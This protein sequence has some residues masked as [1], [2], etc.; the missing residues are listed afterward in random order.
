MQRV[1]PEVVDRLIE[2]S[3]LDQQFC[4]Q[5]K[6]IK[7]GSLIFI[8]SDTKTIAMPLVIF[9]ICKNFSTIESLDFQ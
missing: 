7:V 9:Y 1:V 8:F 2:W 5:R 4:T 3:G 6:M